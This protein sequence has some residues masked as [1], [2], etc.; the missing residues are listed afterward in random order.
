MLHLNNVIITQEVIHSMRIKKGKKGWM[1][2]KINMEKAHDRLR[3]D[4]I[5]DTIEDA[6]LLGNLVR[7]IM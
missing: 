3:W 2:M 1:V 7:L 6:K 5:I 4:F